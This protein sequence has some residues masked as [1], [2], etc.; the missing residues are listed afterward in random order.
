MISLFCAIVKFRDIG[1]QYFLGILN[2]LL[3]FEQ[4]KTRPCLPAGR[5]SGGL[6]I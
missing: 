4:T 2:F 1:H 5:L 3:F 6:G